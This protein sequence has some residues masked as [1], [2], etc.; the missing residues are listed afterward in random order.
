[1]IDSPLVEFSRAWR[2]M[3]RHRGIRAATL[4]ARSVLRT[5]WLLLAVLAGWLRLRAALTALGATTAEH[6]A[7]QPPPRELLRPLLDRRVVSRRLEAARP[8]WP[9]ADADPLERTLAILKWALGR[10][11]APGLLARRRLRRADVILGA[12]V[13]GVQH[14]LPAPVRGARSHA[15]VVADAL[16]LTGDE[17]VSSAQRA[18]AA[19]RLL[20]HDL[21]GLS[22]AAGHGLAVAAVAAARAGRRGA[23]AAGR[24][25][26]AG[27]V[28]AAPWLR[29][30]AVVAAHWLAVASVVAAHGLAAGGVA[31]VR[32]GR[33]GALATGRGVRAGARGAGRAARATGPPLAATGRGV[34]R[35]C[36][37]V[38]RVLSVVVAVLAAPPD[39]R[40]PVWR[41][42][43]RPLV[44]ALVL[45][46]MVGAAAALPTAA[47]LGGS[48]R[49][50]AAGLP[51]LEEMHPLAQPER[52][53]VYDAKG[54][55]I[56]VLHDEQDRIVV[57]LSAIPGVL[58]QAVLA[59]EDER[60]YSHH[61]IDDRGVVRALL[62]NL[63]SREP[64]QGGSTITQ[65]LVRNAYPDLR[66]RSLVRKVKEASLAAQLEERLT[67]DQI[68]EAYLNRVYFGSGYYGVEAASR[69]YF[70]I[71]VGQLNL[72]QAATLAG[73]IREPETSN[74]RSAPKRALARRNTVLQQMA[75]LQMASLS[76]AARA[77]TQPLGVR[78]PKTVGGRYPWFVDA[79]KR[80][81][82]ADPRLGR[83]VA[84]R[85]RMLYE[86]GLRIDTT[87]DPDLQAQAEDAVANWR[88]SSGPDVGLVTIDPRTGAVRAVVGGRDFHKAQFNLAVQGE[89]QAG[90][91]FK[92][93]VLAAAL[94]AGIS[95]DS[96]WESSGFS[97]RKVCG[98]PWTVSNYEGKGSG[99]MRLREATWHSVNG[100]YAR[101]MAE[102]CPT[103]VVAMAKRLGVSVAESQSHAPSIALGSANVSPLEMASAYATLANEGVYQRPVLFT[104]VS[105]H[106][107]T[108]IENRSEGERRIS[109]ALAFQVTDILKGVIRQGTGTA[110]Q[111]G[112]PAAGKTGTTQDYR[113]AWFVGY[114]RQLT[115]AVW[116]GYPGREV[117]MRDV[118]GIRVT[119]G[120]YPA[121][122]WHDFMTVAMVGQPT[123]DWPRPSERLNFSVQPAAEERRAASR[124]RG[125]GR[126]RR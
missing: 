23:L 2:G 114:T 60:F 14:D 116:M 106:G 112:W 70:G 100:V 44:V 11:G 72:T 80:Q 96:A 1:M 69:G 121:R 78:P 15:A 41:R 42:F 88:P 103:R 4:L 113:D 94:D 104:K 71:H 19:A 10:S 108:L 3:S 16:A 30:A 55:L 93:F 39:R 90:S 125:H 32:G 66:D 57:P 51:S 81:L 50:A 29:A 67:K 45:T 62:A 17:L 91:S 54:H 22:R 74:P 26:R 46:G 79:L 47:L 61:G 75:S 123:L 119:G 18:R 86:G 111:I 24:A 115:T 35:A 98:A 49:T 101:V 77:Q 12:K 59:A 95:P 63:L 109:A 122:I 73:L 117:P 27:S 13:L 52:T 31:G 56:E 40:L 92:P 76:S 97:D 9:S 102:L 87:L 38:A 8:P 105:R 64:V 48:F 85:N 58:R 6:F 28:V 37:G 126:G 82:L 68:L 43:L 20:A 36:R 107:R 34:A 120:S 7:G 33:A 110:A 25:L 118:G 53:Q 65:Q 5:A 124:G 99:K 89:R 21:A 83:T 84:Q